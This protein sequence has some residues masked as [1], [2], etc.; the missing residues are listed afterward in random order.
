MTSG[1][2]L[3]LVEAPLVPVAGLLLDTVIEV[4]SGWHVSFSSQTDILTAGPLVEES[5]SVLSRLSSL[6]EKRTR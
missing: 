6:E 5:A 4:P 2:P 3:E 1:T